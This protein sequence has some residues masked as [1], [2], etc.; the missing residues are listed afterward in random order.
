MREQAKSDRQPTREHIMRLADARIKTYT[1]KHK[2][3]HARSTISTHHI[4]RAQTQRDTRTS[5]HADAQTPTQTHCRMVTYI[6]HAHTHAKPEVRAMRCFFRAPRKCWWCRFARQS[7]STHT[8]THANRSVALY[9]STR[10]VQRSPA[11][12]LPERA[13]QRLAPS[14]TAHG[15]GHSAPHPPLGRDMPRLSRR[16]W[17][18]TRRAYA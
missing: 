9:E 8:H 7:V 4:K 3:R 15:A 16:S 17:G 1:H 14:V 10:V 6:E 18:G 13:E 2:Q 12:A 11:T 5:R